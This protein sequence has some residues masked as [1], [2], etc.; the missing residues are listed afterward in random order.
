MILEDTISYLKERSQ[1]MDEA[2]IA[3]YNYYNTKVKMQHKE[4]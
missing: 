2:T 3:T 4:L 1:P